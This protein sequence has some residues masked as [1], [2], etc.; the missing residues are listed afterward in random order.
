MID[1]NGSPVELEGF[2]PGGQPSDEADD[3]DAGLQGTS[4]APSS[5]LR[6]SEQR[7][8]TSRW[9]LIFVGIVT[10]VSVSIGL[11]VA[12]AVLPVIA[13]WYRQTVEEEDG[14]MPRSSFH[15]AIG[16]SELPD[17]GRCGW[18]E[19]HMEYEG[20]AFA[21]LTHV[22][23]PSECCTECQE[24]P[25]C[26]VWTWS[27]D[28]GCTL[29][30][31]EPGRKYVPKKPTWGVSS[32]LPFDWVR[33]NSLYC[34][35]LLQPAGYE[36]ALMKLQM[37][38]RWSLFGCEEYE[39]IS[40]ESFRLASGIRTTAIAGT[41]QCDSGGEFGTALNNDIFK[42]VW[43]KVISN[44]RYAYNDWTVKV[45]ADTA[46]FPQRLKVAI[47][48]HPDT[49]HGIY[50]NNCKFGLH[51]PL[52]VLSR[53]AVTIW[54]KGYDQCKQ[55]FDE[56]C[57]G[58]CLWGEDMFLDQCLQ[59]V[60]NVHRSND[61]NLLSEPHCDSQDWDQCDNH[62]VAFHPFKTAEK[63]AKCMEAADFGS[64]PILA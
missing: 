33:Y 48:F 18:A 35:A 12:G 46:F 34:F 17:M 58:P 24:N 50:L 29:K 54:G 62:K 38:K 31:V 19:H 49:Y 27:V 64:L 39:L 28:K 60:L 26:R 9:S 56:V 2:L 36:H 13:D 41:L 53:Q 10:F 20:D 25:K 21:F 57:S 51:G 40:N 59:K 6:R 37:E 30:H 3:V 11:A 1:D 44:G 5:A 61:W 55:H 63:Y 52:E 22:D 43:E 23:D 8:S 45:D 47:A 32:G 42:L 15:D 4:P 14:S 7:I 16:L